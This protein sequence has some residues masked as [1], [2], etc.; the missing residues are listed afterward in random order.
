MS[1]DPPLPTA[2]SQNS[3]FIRVHVW[4]S[5]RVQ[6]VGYRFSTLH[7][8]RQRDLNGWVRN[9]PDGRVEAVFEGTLTNIEEMIQWC[10][11]GPSA[12]KPE[13]VGVEYEPVEGLQGFEIIR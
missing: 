5:G 9:L 10:H 12:A 13:N 7:Q 6:G 11:H 3:N 8:A 2:N 1:P 4:I